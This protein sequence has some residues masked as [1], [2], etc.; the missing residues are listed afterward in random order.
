[1]SLLQGVTIRTGRARLEGA[2]GA[3]RLAFGAWELRSIQNQ[4][5]RSSQDTTTLPKGAAWLSGI[6]TSIEVEAST[7]IRL[8]S[9][10]SPLN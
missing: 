1:M 4:L 2:G 9:P 3:A 5:D 7:A 8:R 10:P 6:A